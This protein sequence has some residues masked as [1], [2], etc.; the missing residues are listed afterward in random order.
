MTGRLL[1]VCVDDAAG[2]RAAIRGGADR[3][4]LCSG[5]ALGGLTPSVGL[6]RLAARMGVPAYAMIRPRAGDFVF[7]DDEIDLMI[8]D[9][10][11][12]RGAGLSGVVLGASLCDGALD[13][14]ALARLRRAAAGLGTTL[15]RAFDLAG[16]RFEGA[17]ETAVELGFERVLTSGGAPSAPEGLAVL[18][19]LF[20]RARGRIAIMPGAGVDAATLPAL[21]AR[22]PIREAHASCSAPARIRSNE[23]ARLGFAGAGER[24]TDEAAVRALKAALG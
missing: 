10:E 22:L 8:A 2:L 16:P 6:M 15:H 4:E 1:E 9:I 24:A 7:C 20:E 3:I 23:A 21:L 13:R 12:A 11:A 19:R 5:L 17:L 18:E 14:G